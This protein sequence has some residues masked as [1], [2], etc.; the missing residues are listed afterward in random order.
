MRLHDITLYIFS[1]INRYPRLKPWSFSPLRQIQLPTFILASL[2]FH[3]ALDRSLIKTDAACEEAGRPKHG[4]FPIDFFK[5]WE[6]PANISRRLAFELRDDIAYRI[7]GRYTHYH[8][9]MIVIKA[10]R[11]YGYARHSSQEPAQGFFNIYRDARLQD[12]AAVFAY[13]YDVVL[14]MIDAMARY[15]VF[16]GFSIPPPDSF[17]PD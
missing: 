4:L 12:P 5:P 6:F 7:F 11:L 13:P 8:V 2:V 17:N 9:Q 15:A 3:I 10:N 16:H 1:I 14:E